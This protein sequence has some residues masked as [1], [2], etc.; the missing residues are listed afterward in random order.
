MEC[1]GSSL[2]V[3]E[4]F[5]AQANGRRLNAFKVE[6][7]AALRPPHEDRDFVSKTVT[8]YWTRK[9]FVSNTDM[10]WYHLV[11]YYFRVCLGVEN[12]DIHPVLL[13]VFRLI[14]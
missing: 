6:R 8:S 2:S 5:L 4:I 7:C 10:I 9:E 13:V 12:R 3:M 14:Q 11:D 1:Y